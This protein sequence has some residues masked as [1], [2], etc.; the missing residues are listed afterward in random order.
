M[1][2]TQSRRTISVSRRLLER[3]KPYAEAQGVALSALAE[4]VLEQQLGK[5]L[6]AAA[7]DRWFAVRAAR[8][9]ELQRAGGRAS[10]SPWSARHV[11]GGE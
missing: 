3:L 8:I 11:E 9:A 10:R 2:K 6:D 7:F 5:Q 4:F 1:A